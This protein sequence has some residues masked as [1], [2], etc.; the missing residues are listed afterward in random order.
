MLVFINVAV[1]MVLMVILTVQMYISNRVNVANYDDILMF[2]FVFLIV[3]IFSFSIRVYFL[4]FDISKSNP[5]LCV[6][7]FR[8]HT[9]LI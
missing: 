4:I 7:K 9:F 8:C 3:L 1:A 2:Y 6:F 5:K